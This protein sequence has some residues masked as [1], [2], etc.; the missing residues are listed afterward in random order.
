MLREEELIYSGAYKEAVLDEE[1][2]LKQKSKVQW[3]KVGDHNNAYFHNSIKGRLNR[4]RITT[5]RDDLDRVYHDDEVVGVFVSHLHN[6]LGT[7]DK[8][9]SIE[10]P[11]DLFFM[12]IDASEA[13][14]M[15][16]GVTIEEIEA[17]L[18]DIDDDKAPGPDGF[19]SRF[20]KSSWNIVG[21]D[22]CDDV[23]EFF[24]SGKMFG[25]LNTTLIALVRKSRIPFKVS[26]YRLIA[27]LQCR[28]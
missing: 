26:D 5:I 16:R 28:L 8:V 24:S 22:F 6:Y 18:F 3:L 13:L 9:F 15:V 14:Y 10:G 20:F 1:K 23:K 25:E 17:A 19:T 7:S 11:D 2:V 27:L 4:S 21:N 12:K